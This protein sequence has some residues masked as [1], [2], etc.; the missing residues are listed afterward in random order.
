VGNNSTILESDDN[1]V[2]WTDVSV[3][4]VTPAV[5]DVQGDAFLSGYGP[6]ELV[7]GVVADTLAMIVTTSPGT[8]WPV[9]EYAHTGYNVISIEVAPESATQT[10]YSFNNIVRYPVQVFVQILDATT[11]LGT[12]L[13]ETEYTIDWIN[14]SITLNT[15][16]GFSPAMEKL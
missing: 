5:Y 8:N 2:T 12:T 1:G 10:V 14:K 3:F 16:I 6:E 13:A 15:P 7:P 4:A 9:T 11:M